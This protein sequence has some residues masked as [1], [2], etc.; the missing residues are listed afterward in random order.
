MTIPWVVPRLWEGSDCWIIGGGTS[1]PRQFGIP[2]NVITAVMRGEQPPSAYTSY[3]APLHDKHVIGINNA[4]M[5]G[6]W[7]SC[8]FFGDYNW[9]VTHQ[10]PLA[11]WQGLKVSC[12]A[13]F[14]VMRY[15]GVKWLPKNEKKFGG[16]SEDPGKVCWNG[17]SGVAAFSLAYN[18]GVRRILL[19]GFDM[20]LD[21]NNV[22]HWHGSHTKDATT[23]LT[24]VGANPM[25]RAS[26][27]YRHTKYMPDV[28]ADA[29]RLKLEILNVNPDSDIE[30]FPKIKLNQVL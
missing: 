26:A 17:N 4:Y 24:V 19:L 9:Y 2:E 12:A 10:L 11:E 22:S 14:G 7:L 8:V 29:K 28:A 25:R 6:E 15:E 1:M 18:L 5:L 13:K 23:G 30:E 27:F 16:I 21:S 20:K 3:L